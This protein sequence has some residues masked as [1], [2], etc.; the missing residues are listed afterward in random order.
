MRRSAPKKDLL[1][2]PFAYFQGLEK[3][4][5]KRGYL[6]DK[7]IR[8]GDGLHPLY[9]IILNPSSRRTYCFAAGIHGNEIS[10]PWAILNFLLSYKPR[11][12]DPRMILLPVLNPHGFLANKRLN[13]NRINL[14]R[15]FF[16]RPL[17]AARRQIAKLFRGEAIDFF[18]SLHEDDEKKGYYLYRYGAH[19]HIFQQIIAWLKARSSVCLSARIYADRA[20][21]GIVHHPRSDGSLEEWLY[22]RGKAAQS[23]CLEVPDSQTFEHRTRLVS[24]LLAFMVCEAADLL[25]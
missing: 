7:S 23:A 22:C 6:L 18:L 24:K 12:G 11:P 19:E 14:N 8:T 15:R 25:R 10:G 9:K 1:S 4:C 21:G 17:L 5:A 13:Q 16:R 20:A 3:L 2:T